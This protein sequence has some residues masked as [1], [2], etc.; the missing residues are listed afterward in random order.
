MNEHDKKFIAAH[1]NYCRACGG[2]GFF[3]VPGSSVPYGSTYV[4]LP[5]ENELCTFCEE[6]CP[7]CGGDPIETFDGMKCIEC[8]W[9]DENPDGIN[10]NDAE[11]E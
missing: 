6:V 5:D 2:W 1:P 11:G 4:N 3:T 9:C 8:G 7:W 10:L